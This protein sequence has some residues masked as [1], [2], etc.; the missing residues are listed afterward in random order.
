MRKVKIYGKVLLASIDS[1]LHA[2]I[3]LDNRGFKQTL[4]MCNIF[5]RFLLNNC[6]RTQ[7]SVRLYV[8]CL[9]CTEYSI[10]TCSSYLNEAHFTHKNTRS[11]SRWYHA[12]VTEDVF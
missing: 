1:M 5:C 12:C 9:S 10:R 4:G 6:S 3:V 7:L 8:Y 2:N 11:V